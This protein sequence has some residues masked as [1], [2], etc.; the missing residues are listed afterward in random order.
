MDKPSY[1]SVIPA[2]VRYDS[3]LTADEKLLYSEITSLT[4]STGQCFASNRYF[5][6]LY[7]VDERTIRRRMKNLEECGYITRAVIRDDNNEVSDRYISLPPVAQAGPE[8]TIPRDNPDPPPPD[9]TV[10]PSG[11]DCPHP[12]DRIV[13]CNNTR[14]NNKKSL[15]RKNITK[16]KSD[17][18]TPSSPEPATD[19]DSLEKSGNS[20]KK[21]IPAEALE[22]A[23][24]LIESVESDF[25]VNVTYPRKRQWAIDIDRLHRLDRVPWEEIKAYI[26]LYRDN[27]RD[28][29]FWPVIESGHTL[30]KKWLKLCR[31]IREDYP[32]MEKAQ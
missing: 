30:R 18:A 22:C 14:V 29:Q 7:Q 27:H 16:R 12:P 32:W 4:Q 8:T 15:K 19:I 5:A 26:L 3:R 20:G 28:D 25:N 13:R 10:P 31:K 6:K 2:T 17:V 21:E 24:I 23:D 11:Q 9:S 1:F